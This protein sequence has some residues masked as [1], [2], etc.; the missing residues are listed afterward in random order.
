MV[1][2][3][4]KVLLIEPNEKDRKTMLLLIACCNYEVTAFENSVEA[5]KVLYATNSTGLSEY[6]AI[7]LDVTEPE[8]GGIRSIAWWKKHHPES[9]IVG[10]LPD[11]GDIKNLDPKKRIG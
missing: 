7:F 11:G 4:G 5:L 2:V 10:I 8:I 6:D 1:N 3:E 9:C